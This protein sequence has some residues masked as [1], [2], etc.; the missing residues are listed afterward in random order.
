[1]LLA[2]ADAIDKD[3]SEL[4]RSLI[5]IIG[6]PKRASTF[7][8]KRAGAFIRACA[9]R[10]RMVTG[11]WLSMGCLPARC[12]PGRRRALRFTGC[13]SLLG[14]D[15]AVTPFRRPFNRPGQELAPRCKGMPGL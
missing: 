2:A 6:K 10:F 15:R 5:R 13:G 4:V 3:R 8:P 12:R 9:P 7:E 11:T 1:M 14:V